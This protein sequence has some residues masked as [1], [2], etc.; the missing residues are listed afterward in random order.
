VPANEQ[1]ESI[2]N[3]GQKALSEHEEE[4]AAAFLD[5]IRKQKKVR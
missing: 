1:A 5:T 3:L 2:R 4:L